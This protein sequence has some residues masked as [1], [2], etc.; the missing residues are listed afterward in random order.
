[1]NI[2]LDALRDCHREVLEPIVDS[3]S[4]LF[5]SWVET[6]RFAYDGDPTNFASTATSKHYRYA[7]IF[8][9][10]DLLAERT[11]LIEIVIAHEIAHCYNEPLRRIVDEYL[12]LLSLDDDV[13]RILQQ[14]FSD[15]IEYQTEDLAIL[16]CRED[17]DE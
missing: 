17:C 9:S 13:K 2:H 5:P 11:D 8:V 1:M 15:A 16:F 10:K 7:T 3:M 14:T 4:H 6:A 12:P